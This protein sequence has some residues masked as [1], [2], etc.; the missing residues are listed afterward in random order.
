MI[1]RRQLEVYSNARR[2]DGFD[3]AVLD[4]A[5]VRIARAD[6]VVRLLAVGG[7]LIG[8]VMAAAAAFAQ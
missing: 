6:R 4:A 8:S 5:V 1:L 2:T 7:M 3:V